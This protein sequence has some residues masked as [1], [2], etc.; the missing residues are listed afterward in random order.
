MNKIELFPYIYKKDFPEFKEYIK[1]GHLF[2]YTYH[3]DKAI[4]YK[5]NNIEIFIFF[6]EE[7]LNDYVYFLL[8]DGNKEEYC[9]SILFKDCE[10]PRLKLSLDWCFH[11]VFK[12]DNFNKYHKEINSFINDLEYFLDSKKINKFLNH[13]NNN[14]YMYIVKNVFK[15]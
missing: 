5:I 8:K 10:V 12:Y 2:A 11:E 4:K 1:N 13:D 3:F 6:K 14:I 7:L 15:R 9:I